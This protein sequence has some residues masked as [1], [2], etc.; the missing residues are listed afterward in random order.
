MALDT[1]TACPDL[2]ERAY[3]LTVPFQATAKS[4]S[5]ECPIYAG[6]DFY[7]WGAFISPAIAFFCAVPVA[8]YVAQLGTHE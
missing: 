8:T 5:S 2:S 4:L 3:L 6:A 1:P 7:A